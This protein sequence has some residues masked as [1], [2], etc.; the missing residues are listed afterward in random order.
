[1]RYL[2]S[3]SL[4]RYAS[5]NGD[6]LTLWSNTTP[7]RIS[8]TAYGTNNAGM[9]LQKRDYSFI[10][11]RRFD[12]EYDALVMPIDLCVV[13]VPTKYRPFIGVLDVGIF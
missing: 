5:I 2:G 12:T 10:A 4:Q 8:L 3:Q 13:S 7:V 11:S 9:P 1:M 6:L